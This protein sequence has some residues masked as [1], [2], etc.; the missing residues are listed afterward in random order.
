VFS[1]VAFVVL[2]AA[3]GCGD[4]SGSA[5][6]ATPTLL[7]APTNDLSCPASI[8]LDHLSPPQIACSSSETVTCKYA[9]YSCTCHSDHL[10][11]CGAA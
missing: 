2:L 8:E 5:D 3:A 10:F 6:L 4:R 1:R 9:A 11:Y 7:G